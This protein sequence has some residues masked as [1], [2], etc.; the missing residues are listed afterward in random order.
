MNR[1]EHD[2][3]TSWSQIFLPS[4]KWLILGMMIM[5]L[6]TP[7]CTICED[8]DA[9][10]KTSSQTAPV[11]RP[12]AAVLRP[13]VEIRRVPRTD[14]RLEFTIQG[15]TDDPTVTQITLYWDGP[16]GAQ[17]AEAS[18]SGYVHENYARWDNMLVTNGSTAP[19]TIIYT[20]PAGVTTVVDKFS[21]SSSG[22]VKTRAT[23]TQ[24]GG[25]L[26]RWRAGPAK[27][28]PVPGTTAARLDDFYLWETTM[29]WYGVPGLTITANLCQDS[30]GLLQSDTAFVALRFPVQPPSLAYTDPYTLPVYFGD[31]YSPYLALLDER[32]TSTAIL[33]TA[34]EYKPQY[35][36][37]AENELPLA[38]G[39][40]WLTLG[41][42][43]S[44][45]LD[46]A[47]L[48]SLPPDEW[49][50]QANVWLDFD[51][52]RDVGRGAVLPLYYCYEGQAPPGQLVS[53]DATS[54]QGWN[55]TCLGPHYLTLRDGPDNWELAGQVGAWITPTQVISFPHTIY[56]WTFTPPMPLTFTMEASCTLDAG[57][58]FYADKQGQTP[59][60]G[61]IRVDDYLDFWVFG[62]TPADAAP[63]AYELF[64]TARTDDT[65]PA[66]QQTTDLMWV[67]NWVAPPLPSWWHRLCLPLVLRQ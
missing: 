31:G 17:N 1:Q 15:F 65:A 61:P 62:Q 56:N 12:A 25:S 63:G 5:L 55:I 47:G 54:Y 37:F 32:T 34:L 19:V 11:P 26:D 36:T 44:P 9:T 33:T 67:G 13:G 27:P 51:G 48:P 30:V 41:A 35:L 66:W 46:C 21:A 40:H 10:T 20:P 58:A 29:W 6:Q 64:I 57:W 60:A 39:E 38:P 50:V 45:A 59:L 4:K 42:V 28:S 49:E 8:D 43:T 23:T 16:P 18:Y 2:P 3:P 24:L 7:V 14:G 53:A 22:G 52:G